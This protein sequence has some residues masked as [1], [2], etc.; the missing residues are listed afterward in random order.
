MF[1]ANHQIKYLGLLPPSQLPLIYSISDLLLM[2][3]RHENFGNVALEA[4]K[5]GCQVLLSTN[6][7]IVDHLT[8]IKHSTL[9]G[10]S[11][12]RDLSLWSSW[13]ESWLYSYS[14]ANRYVMSDD[15]KFYFSSQRVS[16][17]WL[18]AYTGLLS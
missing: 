10:A 9:W 11:L 16:R 2:P 4:L 3:S 8:Q 1:S 7:G 17:L 18:D 15:F 14:H 6:V 13:L 12:P 5:Q